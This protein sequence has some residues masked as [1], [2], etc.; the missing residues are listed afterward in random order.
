MPEESFYHHRGYLLVAAP[1]LVLGAAGV[2]GSWKLHLGS[3]AHPGPG[4]WP[5][6]LSVAM[7]AMS[8]LLMR[9]GPIDGVEDFGQGFRRFLPG[10]ASVVVFALLFPYVGFSIPGFLLLLYWCRYLGDETWVA[11]VVVAALSTILIVFV[12][13]TL[14]DVPLPSDILL[15]GA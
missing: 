14:L 13:S 4:L 7:V 10:M 15:R 8:L 5:F 2:V 1:T 12:F 3:L 6:I 9:L 11:S